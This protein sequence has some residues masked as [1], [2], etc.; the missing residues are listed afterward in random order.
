[1]E[2]DVNVMFSMTYQKSVTYMENNGERRG[3]CVGWVGYTIV[4]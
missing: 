3:E 1:M 4:M 2:K